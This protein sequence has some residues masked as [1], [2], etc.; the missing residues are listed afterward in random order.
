MK[1]Y[2]TSTDLMKAVREAGLT[3][4]QHSHRWIWYRERKKA[5]VCPK[6]PVTGHRK[7]T[8]RDIREIVRAFSPE[9]GG[10]WKPSL[11][12]FAGG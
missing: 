7:F 12:P 5:L 8:D 3:N 9:G 1:Q 10:K 11:S 2:K 4:D 6:D